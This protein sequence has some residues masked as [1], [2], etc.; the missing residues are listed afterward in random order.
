MDELTYKR[1]D[2]QKDI[3]YSQKTEVE[4][5]FYPQQGITRPYTVANNIF[6]DE[7]TPP[8]ENPDEFNK[9][10]YVQNNNSKIN[11][12]SLRLSVFARDLPHIVFEYM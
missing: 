2:S 6:I 4:E 8:D 9:I 7:L 12:F 11:Y 10:S 5:L 1:L 3:L